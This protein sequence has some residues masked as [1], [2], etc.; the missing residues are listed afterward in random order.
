[1]ETFCSFCGDKDVC[2]SWR[3]I[4]RGASLRDKLLIVLYTAARFR[5]GVWR[6]L[7][8]LTG[9]RVWCLH[10]RTPSGKARLVF[11]ALEPLEMSVI[12]EFLFTTLYLLDVRADT[13]IDC[14]AFRGIS[15]IYLSDQARAGTVIAFEPQKD[16][17]AFLVQRLQ[18]RLPDAVCRNEAVGNENSTVCFAGDGVGGSVGTDGVEIG[19]TRLADLPAIAASRSLLL[20][21]DVEGAEQWILPELLTVLPEKCI[22]L[23]ETHFEDGRSEELIRPYVQSGFKAERV[24]AR[25]HPF[26]EIIYEDWVLKRFH[27]PE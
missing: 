21:M 20:K 3:A 14:G 11:D 1:M 18:Q 24:R 7:F 27:T 17:F 16:N 26:S 22:L 4:A 8:K 9:I 15:T 12:D 19:Q 2:W 10:L 13:V 5:P 25:K 6:L 23:L